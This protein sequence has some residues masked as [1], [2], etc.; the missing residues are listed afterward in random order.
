MDRYKAQI[1]KRICEIK[2]RKGQ[3]ASVSVGDHTP[4]SAIV[5]EVHSVGLR[6]LSLFERNYSCSLVLR[7]PLRLQ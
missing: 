6:Y 4:N 2:S 3:L 5:E 1:R 7:K